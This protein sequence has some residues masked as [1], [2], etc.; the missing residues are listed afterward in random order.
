MP[1]LFLIFS[2]SQRW[3]WHV[4]Y[5]F[6]CWSS[7]RRISDFFLKPLLLFTFCVPEWIWWAPIRLFPLQTFSR[8]QK[9]GLSLLLRFDFS[10]ADSLSLSLFILC[11]NHHSKRH[12]H[13]LIISSFAKDFSLHF[14]QQNLCHNFSSW[15]CFLSSSGFRTFIL[16]FLRISS[17]ITSLRY[18]VHV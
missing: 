6:F 17:P 10:T 9:R 8:E 16:L 1:A 4:R 12:Q 11:L 18:L 15:C 5:H 3:L 14:S 7:K 13:H 2:H